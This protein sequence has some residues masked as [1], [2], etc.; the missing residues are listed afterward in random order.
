MPFAN[1]NEACTTRWTYLLFIL[2]SALLFLSFVLLFPTAPPIAGSIC[3]IVFAAVWSTVLKARLTALGLPHSR[4]VLL[5]FAL[6]VY[7]ACVVLYYLV[8]NG[9]LFVPLLFVI[10][11]TPLVILKER[12]PGMGTSSLT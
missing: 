2:V 11:N 7:I 3:L 8:F 9:R 6:V 4:W 10:L 5:L 1:L 12:S